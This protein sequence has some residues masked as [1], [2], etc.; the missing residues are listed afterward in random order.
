MP[1]AYD[2][3]HAAHRLLDEVIDDGL[4]R[5]D[6]AGAIVDRRPEDRP[7]PVGTRAARNDVTGPFDFVEAA[8]LGRIVAHELDDLLDKIALK[9][10]L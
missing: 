10:Y 5:L 8:Q 2:R 3:S 6:V 7:L 1:A 4:Q 9:N